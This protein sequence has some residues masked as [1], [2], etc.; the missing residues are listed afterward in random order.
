M[1]EI[2]KNCIHCRQTYKGQT[3]EVKHKKVRQ[4]DTC[5]DWYPKR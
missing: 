1:K 3:C 5:D 2:C 4:Q